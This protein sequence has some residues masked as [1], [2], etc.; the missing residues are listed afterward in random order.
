MQTGSKDINGCLCKAM[1]P[2][3]FPN[4]QRAGEISA[5]LQAS[6]TR[7]RW[8]LNPPSESMAVA[9]VENF[10][11]ITMI[12]DSGKLQHC[13]GIKIGAQQ[14]PECWPLNACLI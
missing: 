14:S 1:Y 13:N 3:H 2:N 8:A 12:L 5:L 11:F 4:R 6:G 7:P 10:Y 9:V